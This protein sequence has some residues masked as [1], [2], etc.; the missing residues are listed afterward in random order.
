MLLK[1]E[2][3]ETKAESVLILDSHLSGGQK[4]DYNQMLIFDS[5]CLLFVFTAGS[6]IISNHCFQRCAHEIHI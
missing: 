3:K 4:H 1:E 2:L 6:I 5:L